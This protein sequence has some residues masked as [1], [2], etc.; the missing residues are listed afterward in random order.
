MKKFLL[1]SS[2][3]YGL[4]HSLDRSKRIAQPRNQWTPILFISS[5]NHDEDTSFQYIVGLQTGNLGK[6]Q[7]SSLKRCTLL[8]INKFKLLC[9]PYFLSTYFS[10]SKHS[11]IILNEENSNNV[12]KSLIRQRQEVDQESKMK[13]V[14]IH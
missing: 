3:R 2:S 5:P 1:C 12:I 4:S 7:I 14:F 9:E 13:N 6:F 8:C 11:K 10:F